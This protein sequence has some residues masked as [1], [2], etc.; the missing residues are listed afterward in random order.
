MLMKRKEAKSHGTKQ[1]IEGVYSKGGTVLLVEDVVTWGD[2]IKETAQAI[3]EEGLLV[4]F[5][6]II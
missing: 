5:R 3:R 2:S 4:K 1:L 6:R